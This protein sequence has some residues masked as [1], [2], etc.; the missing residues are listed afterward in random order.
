MS[1]ATR[2]STI[3][4]ARPF[5]SVL[6]VPDGSDA[7]TSGERAHLVWAYSGIAAAA[8]ASVTHVQ[9]VTFNV[10]QDLRTFAIADEN[11]TFAVEQ[12]ARTFKIIKL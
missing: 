8:P 10:A 9:S 4:F 5:V 2:A 1:V 7:A 12:D 6:P 11:R 3:N